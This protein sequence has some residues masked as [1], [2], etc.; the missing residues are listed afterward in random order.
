MAKA[1]GERLGSR[2]ERGGVRAELRAGGRRQHG[3]Q[4]HSHQQATE[5][6]P[7]RAEPKASRLHPCKIYHGKFSFVCFV[8]RVFRVSPQAPGGCRPTGHTRFDE[9]AE[10]AYIDSWA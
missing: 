3:R 1:V 4:A 10:Q 9:T 7:I 6:P 2:R 8:V 5:R